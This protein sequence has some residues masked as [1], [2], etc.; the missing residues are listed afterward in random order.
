MTIDAKPGQVSLTHIAWVLAFVCGGCSGPSAEPPKYRPASN[1]IPAPRS[2]AE[3]PAAV[4]PAPEPDPPGEPVEHADDPTWWCI[5]YKREIADEPEPVTACRRQE[6]ECL[7]LQ[8]A[9]AKG[10][11]DMLRGSTT[12]ACQSVVA[13]HP[14]D[15]HGGREVWQPSKKAGAWVSNGKCQLG[16]SNDGDEADDAFALMHAESVGPLKIGMGAAEVEKHVGEP[17]KRDAREMSP[18]DGAFHQPWSYPDQ[19]L[20]IVMESVE[21]KSPQHIGSVRIVAPSTLKTAR[22]ITIGSP[23]GEVLEHYGAQ[24]DLDHTD[25]DG[26]DPQFVAGSIYGG[27]VFQFENDAVSEIFLGAAAE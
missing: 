9:V 23:R 2:N 6:T 14:G 19:G 22:G 7:A 8:K 3:E 4:D 17:P 20:V 5:C 25:L 26:D 11:R 18:A 15:A 27:L 1:E 24:R 13:T 21:A 12:H 10:G 16:E